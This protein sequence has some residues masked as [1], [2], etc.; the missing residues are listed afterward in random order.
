[1]HP[2]RLIRRDRARE[3]AQVLGPGVAAA[4]DEVRLDVRACGPL[5]HRAAVALPVAAPHRPHE[6]DPVGSDRVEHL[7]EAV[8]AADARKIPPRCRDE[9][10]AVA[11]VVGRVGRGVGIRPSALATY[12]PTSD[13]Y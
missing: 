6:G 11:E 12:D 4:V 13:R 1:M 10:A 5:A 8:A 7:R 9:L 3:S 2:H